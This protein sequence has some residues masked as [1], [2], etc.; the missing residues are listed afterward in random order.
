MEL[1]VPKGPRE[2]LYQRL[3]AATLKRSPASR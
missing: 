1:H 2:R 3:L